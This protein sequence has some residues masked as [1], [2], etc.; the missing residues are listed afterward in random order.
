MALITKMLGI[1]VS[2]MEA[3]RITRKQFLSIMQEAVDNGDILLPEN[4]MTV[5]TVVIAMLDEGLLKHSNYSRQ[6]EE[7]M[8]II[9]TA[10]V[11]ELRQAE[12]AMASRKWW[13][14]WK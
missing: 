6:F 8:N 9:A 10:R 5:V 13:H 3:R 11:A 1:A 7:R 14:I 4:E 12:S 2:D